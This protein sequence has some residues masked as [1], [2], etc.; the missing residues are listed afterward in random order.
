MSQKYAIIKKSTISTQFLKKVSKKLGKNCGFFSNS[1]F[2]GHVSI[3]GVHKSKL[4]LMNIKVIS[5]TCEISEK[6][7]LAVKKDTPL[8]NPLCVYVYIG[9]FVRKVEK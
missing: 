2:L 8:S 5:R 4:M 7:D 9:E 1:I 3:S 6:S